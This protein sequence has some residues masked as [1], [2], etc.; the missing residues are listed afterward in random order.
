MPVDQTT[1]H[2]STD[3]IFNFP[4]ADSISRKGPERGGRAALQ[5]RHPSPAAFSRA[6]SINPRVPEPRWSSLLHPYH[7]GTASAHTVP[8]PQVCKA[9]WRDQDD[10]S[11]FLLGN[12]NCVDLHINAKNMNDPNHVTIYYYIY[13][14]CPDLVL[15]ALE[16]K[17]YFLCQ[18]CLQ[19]FPDIPEAVTCACLKA[20]IR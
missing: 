11:C 17:D 4:C 3:S 5:V 1:K 2:Y 20:F 7:S 14:V 19:F 6:A 12:Y 13:S 10:R 18:L 9:W 16:R 15:L 8:L